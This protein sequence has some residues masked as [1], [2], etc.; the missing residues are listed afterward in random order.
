M[1]TYS[2]TRQWNDEML[3]ETCKLVLK[4]IS[5]PPTAPSGKAEYK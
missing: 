2:S 4:E 1:L 3:N 5:L